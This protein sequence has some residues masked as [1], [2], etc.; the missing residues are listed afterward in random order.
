M[1]IWILAN[2]QFRFP[3]N[4]ETQASECEEIP[5]GLVWCYHVISGSSPGAIN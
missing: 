4:P 2:I 5:L 3:W 1:Y